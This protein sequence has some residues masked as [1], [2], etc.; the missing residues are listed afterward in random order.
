MLYQAGDGVEYAGSAWIAM[1]ATIPM[2]MTPV[3]DPTNWSLFAAGGATGSTG[4]VGPQGFK[5]ATG[6]EGAPGPVGPTGSDGTNGQDGATGATGSTGTTGNTGASGPTGATGSIGPTGMQGAQGMQ[7]APGGMGATG[8]TGP[9]TFN[10]TAGYITRFT[11]ATSGGNSAIYQSASNI[12]IGTTSPGNALS[13][14]ASNFPVAAVAS[15]TGS[16]VGVVMTQ[17]TNAG[18]NGLLQVYLNYWDGS[19]LLDGEDNQGNSGWFFGNVVGSDGRPA[20]GSAGTGEGVQQGVH[21]ALVGSGVVATTVPDPTDPTAAHQLV[22]HAPTTPEAYM[23][24]FGEGQLVRGFAHVELDPK[25]VGNIAVDAAH[26]LRVFIQTEDDAESPG[27]VVQHKTSH[28]FDVV[29][30]M[31]GHSS[32]P[33][34]WQIISNR[35]DELLPGGVVAR[36]SGLR[37]ESAPTTSA[38]ATPVRAVSAH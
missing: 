30:R 32:F 23:M 22:V 26:P 20:R 36:Q 3:M 21:Y 9:G 2:G 16:G 25:L 14:T 5:G 38:G 10:G 4:V 35:A 1:G 37:F 15:S 12:G 6:D 7:G 31:H 18:G 33:F 34:Q 17:I 28:G 29:E 8:A 13:V 19:N 27:V 11:G 24:D